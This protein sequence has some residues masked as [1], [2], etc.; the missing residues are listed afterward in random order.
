MRMADSAELQRSIE[1]CR[2][3]PLRAVSDAVPVNA[4]RLRYSLLSNKRPDRLQPPSGQPIIDQMLD[5]AHLFTA[6]HPKL[7]RVV[8]SFPFKI[9]ICNSADTEVCRGTPS[10]AMATDSGCAYRQA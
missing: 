2:K 1:G 3:W 6:L 4:E 7:W 10:P 5:L 8:G 9:S